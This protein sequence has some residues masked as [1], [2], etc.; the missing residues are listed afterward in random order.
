MD[1]LVIERI[2]RQIII[3]ASKDRPEVIPALQAQSA[4]TEAMVDIQGLNLH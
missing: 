4:G 3:P 1:P 2:L